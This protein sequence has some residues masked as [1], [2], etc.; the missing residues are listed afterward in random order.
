ML[1][2][3]SS[4]VLDAMSGAVIY[5]HMRDIKNNKLPLRSVS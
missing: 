1:S 2:T 4:K 3:L 5:I